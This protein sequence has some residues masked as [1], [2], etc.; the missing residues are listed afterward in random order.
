MSDLTQR[1]ERIEARMVEL[2]GAEHSTTLHD[3]LDVQAVIRDLEAEIDK[4]AADLRALEYE[5]EA[6]I[7][8]LR[9]ALAQLWSLCEEV[10]H[11]HS[12]PED[13]HYNKCEPGEACFWCEETHR[14]LDAFAPRR[15]TE[16]P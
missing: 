9:A 1:A 3:L 11:A 8:R 15:G 6:E 4:Q 7:A 2:E 10:W 13:D 12:D 5:L 14:L 16:E